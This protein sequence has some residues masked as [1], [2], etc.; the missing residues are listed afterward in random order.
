MLFCIIMDVP[1]TQPP[2]DDVVFSVLSLAKAYLMLDRRH[3]LRIY[4]ASSS[5]IFE[6]PARSGGDGTR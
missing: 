5:P 1:V 6:R 3:E 2:L 4:A